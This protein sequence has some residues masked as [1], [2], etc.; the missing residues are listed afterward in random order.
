MSLLELKLTTYPV[1][2]NL[3]QRKKT[4]QQIDAVS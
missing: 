1:K 3:Y 2:N 4:K